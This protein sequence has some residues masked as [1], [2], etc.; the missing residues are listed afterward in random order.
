MFHSLISVF[1]FTGKKRVGSEGVM[2]KHKK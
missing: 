2:G 1:C